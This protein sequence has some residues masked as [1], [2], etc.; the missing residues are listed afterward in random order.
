MWLIKFRNLQNY[1]KISAADFLQARQKLTPLRICVCINLSF[2]NFFWNNQVTG[3][4][5]LYQMWWFLRY[6]YLKSL[7]RLWQLWSLIFIKHIKV[8]IS[9]HTQ[10]VKHLPLQHTNSDQTNVGTSLTNI[11]FWVG[12]LLIPRKLINISIQLILTK[13]YNNK[14]INQ[15]KETVFV[16]IQY[17][18]CRNIMRNTII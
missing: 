13:T 18:V 9:H 4:L 16:V 10:Y 12:F 8:V 7:L 2:N 5:H 14:P 17:I 15:M 6:I 3:Y 1:K 11:F